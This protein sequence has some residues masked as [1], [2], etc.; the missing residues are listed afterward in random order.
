MLLLT[1][2]K[3]SLTTM[4]TTFNTEDL[5]HIDPKV[6]V[7]YRLNDVEIWVSTEPNHLW[8]L[9]TGYSPIAVFQAEKILNCK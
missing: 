8:V 9:G 3:P 1:N 4:N 7:D 2:G 5:Y 6:S